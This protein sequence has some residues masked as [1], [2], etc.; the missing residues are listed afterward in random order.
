MVAKAYHSYTSSFKGLSKEVWLLSAVTLINRAGTTLVPFL[1]LFL[2]EDR[3]FELQDVAWIMSAYGAGSIVGSWAGGKLIDRYGF[4]PVIFYS[5]LISGLMFIGLQWMETFLSFSIGIFV[6]T[7]VADASRPASMVAITAYSS[8]ENR[9]RSLTLLRL[10][11]NLGFSFGPA[12]GGIFIAAFGYAVL[13]WADG[14][15]CITAALLFLFLLDRKS[16]TSD[17]GKENAPQ[18]RSPYKDVPFLIFTVI[19]FVTGFVFLQFLA[20]MP[21]FYRQV[22]LLSEQSIGWLLGMNGVLIFLFEMPFIKY[23]EESKQSVF[24]IL[25][26]GTILL[27]ISFLLLNLTSWS[28]ILIV[29]MFFMTVGEM[30]LFPFMTTFAMNRADKG[31]SGAYMGLFSMT[32]SFSHIFGLNGGLQMVDKI[33]YQSTWFIMAAL[34]LLVI[35]LIFFLKRKINREMAETALVNG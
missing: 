31:K 20:S 14:V 4:H 26:Q 6:L 18:N 27:M 3:G 7:C 17:S 29:G 32:F 34:L 1:S 2:T 10:A 25:I 16:A 24:R 9:T 8:P 13:F 12:M 21:L 5:L 23:Y 33:G 22:H 15:T 30:L 11:I 28:G 19:C 35:G